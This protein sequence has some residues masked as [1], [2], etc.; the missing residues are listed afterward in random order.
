MLRDSGDK[1]SSEEKETVNKAIE[2]AKKDIEADNVDDIRKALEELSKTTEPIVSKLYQNAG[3]GAQ[4]AGAD[5]GAQGAGNG[6]EVNVDPSQ[7][8]TEENK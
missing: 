1:L 8:T 5:N 6:D 2:K 4:G 3:A 7:Y